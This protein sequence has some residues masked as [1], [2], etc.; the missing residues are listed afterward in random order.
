MGKGARITHFATFSHLAKWLD[1]GAAQ[2]DLERA[3]VVSFDVFDTL[4]FRRCS[5]ETVQRGVATA[6]SNAIGFSSEAI[7][8]VLQERERAFASVAA[9]NRAAGLDF[10][11]HLNAINL[12]WVKEL[13]PDNPERWHE[14]VS[15]VREAKIRFERWACYS[16]PLM[17]RLLEQLQQR[18]KRLVFISDMYLGEEVVS[19]L[20]AD[21]GL[22]QYFTTGYV[23]GDLALTKY[24]GRLFSHVLIAEGLTPEQV[25]HIGDNANVD[26]RRAAKQGIR[27]LVVRERERPI[28]RMLFDHR[29]ALLDP[30]WQGH[31]AARFASAAA[32]HALEPQISALGR[33][34]LGPPFAAFTHGLVEYCLRV[35]PDAVYFLSREGMLLRDLYDH[36]IETM[37]LDIPRGG[38]LCAS[39][40]S[41]WKAAMR[42]YG[43]REVLLKI[44]VGSNPTV[45]RMMSQLQFS[46][47]ELETLA[48]SCGVPD[49][50]QPLNIFE[51]PAFL[52]LVDH[53]TVQDRARQVGE[54][55]REDLRKYLRTRG[56]FEVQRVVI[57]DVGW[58]GQIQEGLQLALSD[59]ASPELHVYYLGAN[60]D[61]DERRRAGLRIHAD[62]ADMTRYEWAGGATFE[63]VELFEIPSRAAHGTVVGHRDGE[64][65]LMAEDHP[66]RIPELTDEPNI[67][68]LQEGIR[69]FMLQYSRYAAMTGMEA[70][71]AMTYA[72]S[73]IARVVRFPRKRELSLFSSLV[74]MANFGSDERI[75]LAKVPSLLSW[76]KFMD[77]V[78]TSNWRPGAAALGLG[79]L[80]SLVHS[81][82]R[83]RRIRMSLPQQANPGHNGSIES[84]EAARNPFA[85]PTHG[86]EVDVERYASTLAAQARVVCPLIRARLALSIFEVSSLHIAHRLANAHLTLKG[87]GKMPADLLPIGPWFWRE[88]YIRLPLDGMLGRM[89]RRLRQRLGQRN[90]AAHSR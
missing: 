63:F 5:A 14:L 50:D 12:A 62:V 37:G 15:I 1:T 80:G 53:P 42:G 57:V 51:S 49:L 85:P 86:F 32:H 72:R 11:A 24:S 40:L 68:L 43:L 13:V 7:D 48:H 19:I 16:N 33:D 59:D 58:A 35:K 9:S 45:R 44:R 2:R 27:A 3:V 81:I 90:T 74:H 46:P 76:R 29:Y 25:L 31:N 87:L 56:F 70:A 47:S 78:N 22:R 10:D 54:G 30:R 82:F 23:S 38:Y 55:A 65:L 28:K 39:R 34:V 21:C 77:A 20:L 69:D 52:R 17:P 71:H 36:L 26:G 60:R 73:T 88:I 6:L 18:G 4:L 67:A 61:A 84:K 64:P 89:A 41:A 83:A 75:N 8:S 79:R 66:E